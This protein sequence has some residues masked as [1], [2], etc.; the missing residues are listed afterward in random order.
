V[1]TPILGMGELAARLPLLGNKVKNLAVL[2]RAGVRVPRGFGLPYD[3]YSKHVAGLL[4]ALER[5]REQSTNYGDMAKRLQE[6]MVSAPFAGTDEVLMA[7]GDHMSGASYFAVRSSGAPVVSG[8]EV[9]EDSA[10]ASLAGQYESYLLVPASNVPQAILWCFASLFSERCLRQFKVMEDGGYLWSRMSV[11]V[12]EMCIADLSAVVMTRDPV[13]GGDNLGMEVT[14]GACEALVSGEVQ[15]DL[16]LLSRTTGAILSAEVGSKT[17]RVGYE[18]L[19]SHEMP[20]KVN[21]PL[22]PE[23]RARYAASQGLIAEI[24]RLGMHIEHHFGA[25]QDIELVVADGEI[26]VTQTRP[27]TASK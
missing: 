22:A 17:S 23:Q 4:P 18:P 10:E 9:A 16:Y 1:T 12:Q 3:V 25:P 15:G 11:L 14:Y 26:V 8:R 20:N 24:Y 27:I 13:E 7:L 19:T 5:V 2:A 6:V 21:T